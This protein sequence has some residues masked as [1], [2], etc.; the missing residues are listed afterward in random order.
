MG[1]LCMT[2]QTSAGAPCADMTEVGLIVP[3]HRMPPQIPPLARFLPR[4]LAAGR[5]FGG[6]F[7][8]SLSAAGP[9]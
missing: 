9:V 3:E 8:E 5:M 2:R 6:P 7:Y 4:T 1:H